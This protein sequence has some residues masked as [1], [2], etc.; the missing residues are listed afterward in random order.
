M[1]VL[2]EGMDEGK[3]NHLVSWKVV[4]LPRDKGDLV[5]NIVA[6]NIVPLFGKWLW[7]FLVRA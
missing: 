1:N 3:M 2:W 7:R 6:R 4:S 5:G